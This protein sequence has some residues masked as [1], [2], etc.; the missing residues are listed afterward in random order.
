MG[1]LSDENDCSLDV[2]N[3]KIVLGVMLCFKLHFWELAKKHDFL[4]HFANFNQ[5]EHIL[6]D[7]TGPLEKH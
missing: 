4:Q 6:K 7:P 2:P 5:L 3:N 1:A